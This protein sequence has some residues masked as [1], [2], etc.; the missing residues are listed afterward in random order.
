MCV[1]VMQADGVDRL[2]LDSLHDTAVTTAN[3]NESQ[4]MEPVASSPCKNA[5]ST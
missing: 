5:Q 4:H 3:E 2:T 1:C